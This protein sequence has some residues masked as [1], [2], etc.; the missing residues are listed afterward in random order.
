MTESDRGEERASY[1]RC[2]AVLLCT[3]R[4]FSGLKNL[5][6]LNCTASKG[7]APPAEEVPL[8]VMCAVNSSLFAQERFAASSPHPARLRRFVFVPE[9]DPP[10]SQKRVGS[11]NGRQKWYGWHT[12]VL[13]LFLVVLGVTARLGDVFGKP[14]PGVPAGEILQTERGPPLRSGTSSRGKGF[15]LRKASAGGW[16]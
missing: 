1:G 4:I 12:A 13:A 2:C 7:L 11:A 6:F 8:H 16:R 5:I 3:C 9:C 15:P 10:L 14:S